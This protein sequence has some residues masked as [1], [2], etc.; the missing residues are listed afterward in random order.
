MKEEKKE[1]RVKVK[2]L[3]VCTGALILA[4][5]AGYCGYKLGRKD[6]FALAEAG[7]MNAMTNAV[8]DEVKK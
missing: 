6:G 8:E 1:L 7:L 5:T 4:G 3:L 2:T